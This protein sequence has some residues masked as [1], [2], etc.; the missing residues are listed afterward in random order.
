MG[1]GKWRKVVKRYKLPGIS[2]RDKMYRTVTRANTAV[3]RI[4][5]KAV[6]RVNPKS[7]YHKEKCFS[8]FSF[9]FFSLYL[10]EVIDVS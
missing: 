6:R 9:L 8:F 4:Y 7:S 2:T 1:E 5:R 3:G 10:Y